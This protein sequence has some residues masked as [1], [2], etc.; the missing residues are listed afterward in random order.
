MVIFLFLRN[1][2]ATIIPSLALP[3]SIIGTFAVMYLLDYSLDNLSMMAL[4][5]SVG[6]VVDDAIVML[7]NIVRHIEMGEDRAAGGARRLARDRLHDRVDDAVAR[8][9]VHPG[10]V[11]G[12][13]PRPAVPR[14]RGDDLRR[15]SDLRRRV[16][17]ADADAVQP[18][19]AR[20]HAQGRRTAAST[21]ASSARSTA[22]CSGYE[23]TLQLVLRH[24]RVDAGRVRRA[25]ASRTGVLFVVVPKGFIPEQDT[26]QIFVHHRGARRASSFDEM[27]EHA[28]AGRRHHPRRIPN[29]E[30]V[31]SFV[32]ARR[33]AAR[34]SNIGPHHRAPEAAQRAQASADADHR[35]S[36]GRSSP[37]VPGIKAYRAELADDPHRRPG[38][39]EPVPVHAAGARH[40]RAVRSGRRSS[41]RS[42][43]TLPGLAGRHERPA[44][45][46]A[47][48]STVDIDRDKAAAL[49]VTRRQIENALY[50]A[51]GP[52]QVST[53]YAPTNEYKVLLE[54]EPQLPDRSVGAVAALRRVRAAARSCRSTRVAT[55]QAD[56]RA[57]DG[58]PPR[59]A[60]GGDDLVRPAAGRL[61]R[62]RRSTQIDAATR[63]CTLPATITGSFQGTAQ[64]FQAS[65]QRAWACC[66]FIAIL[67]DLHRARHPVRE[68]HPPAHDSVGPAVG[69]LRRAASR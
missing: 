50:D 68:L 35:R 52:R 34:R 32:G 12:R 41:R 61:A 21:R 7:E 31:M 1:V 27:V 63:R 3:F 51:Y 42:C 19:P 55:L 11:H 17:D 67:V 29:V 38:E 65:L 43:A 20:P 2:S 16:A 54:L 60:A 28:A 62:R 58:Q 25:S 57:A 18:L 15:D 66:S 46:A 56:G 6:F 44:D 64:A 69:R 4:I 59:P 53:I 22:C 45:H 8:R 48:R 13:H 23:R 49:G 30:D 36:C 10:A 24:R 14:V 39:Q 37:S 47:R 33:L 9:G 40:R 5:L 26:D